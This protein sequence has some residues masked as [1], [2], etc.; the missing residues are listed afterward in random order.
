MPSYTGQELIARAMAAADMHDNFVTPAT[1]LQWASLERYAL[2]LFMARAG[3]PIDYLA[4]LRTVYGGE[5]GEFPLED[6][7]LAVADLTSYWNTAGIDTVIGRTALGGSTDHIIT[8]VPDST[9]GDEYLDAGP[10][11]SFHYDPGTTTTAVFEAQVAASPYFTVVSIASNQAAFFSNGDDPTPPTVIVPLI[12][13]SLDVM[14]I[15]CVHQVVDNELRRLKYSDTVTFLRQLPNSP[16][17]SSSDLTVYRIKRNLD[18]IIFNFFPDPASGVQFLA[19]YIPMPARLLAT[20][21]TVS[22]PM[23]WE[24]RIVLGMARRALAKEE[25]DTTEIRG[26]IREIE[27]QIEELA[28]NKVMSESPSVRNVDT[29]PVE[30]PARESW[31]WV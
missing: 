25:A 6:P 28:W 1:W 21:D 26:Q 20:T 2:E 5:T 23:G 4:Q 7:L 27:Q 14:A 22:Y 24:E 29:Q 11:P 13:P 3:W 15:V 16:A 8:F 9:P 18:G 31:I 10:T 30:L 12:S 19:T 17:H